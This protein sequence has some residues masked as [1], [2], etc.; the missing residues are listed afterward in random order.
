MPETIS[1]TAEM[2]WTKR[3]LGLPK[4]D[5]TMVASTIQLI[6]ASHKKELVQIR[7]QSISQNEPENPAVWN[8]VA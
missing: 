1:V 4:S 7:D 6:R 5:G 2:V 8:I 3:K